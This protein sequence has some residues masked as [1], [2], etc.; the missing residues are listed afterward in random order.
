[1]SPFAALYRKEYLENRRLLLCF[2]TACVLTILCGCLENAPGAMLR[3]LEYAKL[4]GL[5]AVGAVAALSYAT[6]TEQKTVGFLRAIPID[7]V[8][9]LRGKLAWIGTVAL[10]VFAILFTTHGL[11]RA[12]LMPYGMLATEWL[13]AALSVFAW[14]LFWST[15]WPGTL[16]AVL[17]TW[18]ICLAMFFGPWY[19]GDFF[20]RLPIS[21]ITTQLLMSLLILAVAMWRALHFL[22][23][24]FL[25][26]SKKISTGTGKTVSDWVRHFEANT[27]SLVFR[28]VKWSPFQA[29]LWQSIRQ[30]ATFLRFGVAL[31]LLFTGWCWYHGKDF[32]NICYGG[33]FALH[34]FS[35]MSSFLFVGGGLFALGFSA[36]I[37]LPDQE[38]HRYRTLARLGISPGS[39][40]WSRMLPAFIV[41][42]IPVPTIISLCYLHSG[43]NFV[44][45]PWPGGIAT[46]FILL[47]YFT[48]F[49]VGAVASLFC[50]D[51]ISSV[52]VTLVAT[53]VFV[54]YIYA[55]TQYS[56]IGF[57]LAA[58]TVLAALLV[59]SRMTTA[60]WLRER[61]V[62]Q[63][64]LKTVEVIGATILLAGGV[65]VLTAIL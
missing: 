56:S 63:R 36:V 5:C 15:I 59:A 21:Y 23:E 55:T 13:A 62:G 25:D 22:D 16:M 12:F 46:G 65:A 33:P 4:L 43:H 35:D 27:F 44:Q 49:C 37:F 42:S 57:S 39:L 34:I 31:S 6:E 29:L 50:R 26:D 64:L 20:A 28:R 58:L 10:P 61:S 17:T 7:P 38:N 48:P 45:N 41:Y 18:L 51:I 9:L 52:F 32:V 3:W 47:I 53:I 19:F 24:H 8:T 30:S 14:G 1:M 40:W 54:P 60:D 2:P 11:L